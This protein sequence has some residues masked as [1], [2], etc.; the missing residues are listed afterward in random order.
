MIRERDDGSPAGPVRLRH[1]P[2]LVTDRPERSQGSPRTPRSVRHRGRRR[3]SPRV[4]MVLLAGPHRRRRTSWAGHEGKEVYHVEYAPDGRTFVTAGQ[5]RTA[6]I[7]DAETGQERLVLRGHEDEV[8]WASF[9]PSGTRVVTAGDDATVRI[10]SASDGRELTV[11]DR[12]PSHTVAALFTPDGRD[13]IAAARDGTVVRWDAA[14]GRRRAAYRAAQRAVDGN[15]S[16]RWRSPRRARPW[17]SRG[18]ADVV[19][20]FDLS[21][22]GLAADRH[23]DG[24][25][26][27]ATGSA[28]PSLPT[29]ARLRPPA[30]VARTPSLRPASGK[31]QIVLEGP[32]TASS[33]TLAFAPDGRTLAVGDGQG[34][35]RIWDLATRS[36]QVSLLGHTGRIWSVAFAPDGRTLATTGRD[37]TI[38]LWDA[39]R[40]S[41]RVVFRGLARIPCTRQDFGELGGVL[42]RRHA[43][44]RRKRTGVRARLQPEGWYHPDAENGRSA[45]RRPV[46]F[47]SA[48]AGRM[49]ESHAAVER[50]AIPSPAE[51]PSDK[52]LLPRRPE[53]WRTPPAPAPAVA[54]PSLRRRFLLVGHSGDVGGSAFSPDGRTLATASLDKTVRLWSVAAARSGRRWRAT[55]RFKALPFR[56]MA[57]C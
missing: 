7:W 35:L 8:D 26:W 12:L 42:G 47:P 57:R 20:L 4:R 10:W 38:R 24:T 48:R 46:P 1:P 19:Q 37:G 18:K 17:P 45:R 54:F 39:R 27:A 51:R 34:E 28:W 40:R 6:R 53:I 33:F 23:A 21:E 41:D 11:L 49:E 31:T 14:T 16:R 29:A 25:A 13:V 5:D 22:G 3:G 36:F 55:C 32:A 9:D 2:R 30:R 43:A 52:T 15:G 56:P 44:P 50:Q